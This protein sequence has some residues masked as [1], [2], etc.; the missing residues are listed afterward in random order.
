MVAGLAL[1]RL[2]DQFPRQ[3]GAEDLTAQEAAIP[4]FGQFTDARTAGF[5]S[6]KALLGRVSSSDELA[7]LR[8]PGSGF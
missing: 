7:F 8:T 5:A 1:V 6:S 2:L 3:L 4:L